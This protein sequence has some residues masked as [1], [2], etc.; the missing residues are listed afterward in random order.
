MFKF[1]MSIFK[2]DPGKKILK[3]RDALYKKSVAL[4]RNGDLREYGIIMKRIEDLEKEYDKL[5]NNEQ[6]VTD[7]SCDDIDYDG[8]GNQGRF[9]TH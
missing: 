5:K 8:M 9:P 7:T 3:E 6:K 4:Q 1:L 2:S